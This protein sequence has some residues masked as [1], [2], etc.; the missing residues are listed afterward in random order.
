MLPGRQGLGVPLVPP[1]YAQFRPPPPLVEVVRTFLFAGHEVVQSCRETRETV[2]KYLC[3]A[4]ANFIM[5]AFSLGSIT[6]SLGKLC[7]F[8]VAGN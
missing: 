3:S 1:R 7:L 8:L 4:D 2:R 5:K 6:L